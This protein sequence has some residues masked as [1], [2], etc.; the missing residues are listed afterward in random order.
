MVVAGS[1]HA[2]DMLARLYARPGGVMLVEA[3]TYVDALHIFRDQQ[4]ELCSIPI[5]EHGRIPSELEKLVAQLHS[6]G[7]FPSMLYSIANS[8]TP[9]ASSWPEAGHL[10]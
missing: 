9:T 2:V 5:D 6:G 10:Q 4:V 8:H 1:T 7:P 3:P